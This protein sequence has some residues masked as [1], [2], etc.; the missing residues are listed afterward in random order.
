MSLTTLSIGANFDGSAT[1]EIIV[2]ATA[3]SGTPD[4][5]AELQWREVF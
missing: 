5:A 3:V 4:I 2:A 1:H